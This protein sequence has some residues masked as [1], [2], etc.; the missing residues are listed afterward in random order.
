MTVTEVELKIAETQ[1]DIDQMRL[2]G[3]PEE[4]VREKEN[5]LRIYNEM[6]A[7]IQ[8][9]RYGSDL[10]RSCPNMLLK[11]ISKIT[12]VPA[13]DIF[14]KIRKR[15]IVDSRRLYIYLL[16]TTDPAEQKI[17]PYKETKFVSRGKHMD[18]RDSPN[19]LARHIQKDHATVLHY[20]RTTFELIE[21]DRYYRREVNEIQMKL[22]KGEIPMPDITIKAY[23]NEI[24]A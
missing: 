20:I 18:G 23:D 3:I 4:I 16:R 15:E 14:R 1:L 12:G 10:D 13:G 8:N 22:L 2:C 9:H 24:S 6:V 17:I 7:A 5:Q 11:E 19:C 21:S